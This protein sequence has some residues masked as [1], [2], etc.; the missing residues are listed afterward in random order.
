MPE[1][2]AASLR[3]LWHET[4]YTGT[5]TDH[6]M[7]MLEA[8]VTALEEVAAARWPRRWILARR[9]RRSLRA[10]TGPYLAR[11]GSFTW[12]RF[13]SISDGWGS[14]PLPPPPPRPG[15]R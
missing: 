11:E 5:T 4:I 12:A 2:T 14:H 3:R 6:A 1:T 8:R 9:L 15:R 13:Q 7:D 10:S